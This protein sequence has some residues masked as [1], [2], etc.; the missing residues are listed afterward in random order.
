MNLLNF[1]MPRILVAGTGTTT[2]ATQYPEV[3]RHPAKQGKEKEE[4]L[5]GAWC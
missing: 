1:L 3:S 2:Q 4:P 5:F